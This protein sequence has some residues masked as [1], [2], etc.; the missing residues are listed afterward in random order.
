M[1]QHLCDM[2]YRAE[3]AG[4]NDISDSSLCYMLQGLQ[5]LKDAHQNIGFSLEIGMLK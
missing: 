1:S 5:S 4:M 3:R 2:I